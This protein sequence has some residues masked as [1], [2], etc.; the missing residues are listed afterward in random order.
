MYEQLDAA[1][2]APE[3]FVL[4]VG[5][6]RSGTTIVGAII[7]SHPHMLCANESSA[8]AIFWRDMNRQQILE[9][10]IEN[11][12][13][14]LASDRPSE[15]YLY[16]IYAGDKD[17]AA[18][19]VIGDKIWNP[20][21]LLIAGQRNLLS[22]LQ[23]RTAA[24]IRLVHCVRNPFDVVATMHKRSGAPLRDRLRWYVMHCEAIQ[25]IIEREESPI[26][27]LRHENLIANPR[28]VSRDMFEWLGHPTTEEHLDLI[29]AKVFQEP[30]RTRY[31]IQWPDDLIREVE[32]LQIRFPFLAGYDFEDRGFSS[33]G[34][35]GD[36]VGG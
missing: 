15:G 19:A 28:A 27:L 5:N 29:Q 6:A 25:I 36:L 16:A 26:M 8:S 32:R 31:E 20:A 23:E 7:D 14:N 10:M 1:L 24:A 18:I 9:N 34:A 2:I 33:E 35:L 3:T 13:R 17:S 12:R 30:R 4:V 21:L 22:S 11:C